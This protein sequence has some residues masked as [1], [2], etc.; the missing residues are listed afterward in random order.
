[1]IDIDYELWSPLKIAESE[2]TNAIESIGELEISINDV[3]FGNYQGPE[4]RHELE[5]KREYQI[6]KAAAYEHMAHLITI[7]E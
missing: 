5:L 6:A 7:V 2:S 4:T 1:M 3:I